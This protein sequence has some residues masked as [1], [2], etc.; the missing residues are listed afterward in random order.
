MTTYD[1]TLGKFTITTKLLWVI[2]QTQELYEKDL[3]IAQIND[4]KSKS[5]LTTL[6]EY[7]IDM[8]HQLAKSKFQYNKS[9]NEFINEPIKQLFP[10]LSHSLLRMDQLMP[11]A[12]NPQENQIILEKFEENKSIKKKRRH[13]VLDLVLCHLL[14][15]IIIAVFLA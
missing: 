5:D 14:I 7:D 15:L 9:K 12:Y 1:E 13:Y 8:L 4:L 3:S 11:L 6:T 10:G 2:P